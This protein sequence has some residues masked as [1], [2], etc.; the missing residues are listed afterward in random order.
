MVGE[1]VG[2]TC[3]TTVM[4]GSNVGTLVMVGVMVGEVGG[5]W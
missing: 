3:A 4:V 1:N 5:G 2:A